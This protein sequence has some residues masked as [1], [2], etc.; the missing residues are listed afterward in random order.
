M[1][2]LLVLG[3]L[4][5]LTIELKLAFNNNIMLEAQVHGMKLRINP[6]TELLI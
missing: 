6:Q 2:A 3:I 4:S 1:I 5:F